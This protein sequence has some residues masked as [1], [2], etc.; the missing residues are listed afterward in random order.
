MDSCNLKCCHCSAGDLPRNELLLT[1]KELDDLFK[2]MNRIGTF[3]L[4]L[5]GGEPL[6]RE[7]LFDIIDLAIK[8]GLSPCLT[9]NGLLLTEKIAKELGKR[10]LAWLNISL[11]GA[12][13]ETNDQ[14]RGKG[15]F[16]EAIQKIKMASKYCHFSIAFTL[17]KINYHESKACAKLAKELGAQAAIFRPLYPI[18]TAS[19]NLE[20]MP[21]FS[22]YL[23]SLYNLEEMEKI[24]YKSNVQLCNNHHWG[25][26][27]RI[28]SRSIVFNNFGC[29]AGNIVCSISASGNISP[30]SYLPN[31]FIAGNIKEKSLEHIWHN[32]PIFKNIRAL[33]TN[34]FCIG[35]DS[36]NICHGGCRARALSMYNSIDAPDLWACLQKNSI[37]NEVLE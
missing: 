31:S 28:D 7:D 18:G 23:E 11:E 6:L 36:Y 27:A 14:I 4:G 33:K 9:T 22:E 24:Y 32:S 1:I 25:P 5:T 3:R 34:N 30:C 20:L 19:K 17:M 10:K 13:A 2:S 21:S 26:K 8:Y 15:T 12:T 37:M 16:N 29:G 35:C